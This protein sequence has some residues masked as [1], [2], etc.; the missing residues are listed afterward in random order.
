MLCVINDFLDSWNPFGWD[1]KE[2]TSKA[3]TGFDYLETCCDLL[4]GCDIKDPV[5]ISLGGSDLQE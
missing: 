1:L 4:S 3:E 5:I 2:Q